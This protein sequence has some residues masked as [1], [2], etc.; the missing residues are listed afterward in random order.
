MGAYLILR[1]V[2]HA[3]R[4]QPLL[5]C[6]PA[7][8]PSSLPSLL[9]PLPSQ[10]KM[11]TIDPALEDM[12]VYPPSES[13]SPATSGGGGWRAT[14]STCS[15]LPASDDTQAHQNALAPQNTQNQSVS[16]HLPDVD[17][18]TPAVVQAQRNPRTIP[19]TANTPNAP[20]SN[21]GG[22]KR[23]T[24]GGNAASAA[25]PYPNPSSLTGLTASSP[26][27]S[28]TPIQLDHQMLH[29]TGNLPRTSCPQPTGKIKNQLQARKSIAQ[30][31]ADCGD[32]QAL[33]HAVLAAVNCEEYRQ[34][35][36]LLPVDTPQPWAHPILS[37]LSC[38]KAAL[39]TDKYPRRT[40]PYP[41]SFSHRLR[42]PLAFALSLG[43]VFPGVAR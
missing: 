6:A 19:E 33:K 32:D 40:R 10:K 18:A 37:P 42:K 30:A 39:N 34:V 7:L 12:I 43:A 14:A 23:R 20:N 22:P 4:A 21:P 15:S 9:R 11:T 24:R 31:L 17:A 36:V 8:P 38:G 5:L 25:A 2:S 35:R 28:S 29:N 27:I 41:L 26:A 1:L 3:S 13:K 16:P